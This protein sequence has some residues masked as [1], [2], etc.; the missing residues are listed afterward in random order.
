M[1][2]QATPNRTYLLASSLVELPSSFRVAETCELTR[3]DGPRAERAA[4]RAAAQRLERQGDVG[5]AASY[6]AEL[7]RMAVASRSDYSEAIEAAARSLELSFDN[8]LYSEYVSLLSLCGN[9]QSA[10]NVTSQKR[11][12]SNLDGQARRRLALFA[13]RAGD[14]VRAATELTD[15][16]RLEPEATDVLQ[17]LGTLSFSLPEQVSRERGILAFHEV[18]RRHRVKGAVLPSFEATLRAFELDPKNLFAAER[19]AKELESQGRRE[20]A[21]EV[22]RQSA[23]AAGDAMRHDV[24][25]TNALQVGDVIA[26]FAALLDGRADT[27]FEEQ[28]IVRGVEQLLSPRPGLSQGFDMVLSELGCADWLAVRLE[29]GPLLERWTDEASAQVVLARLE[30]GYFAHLDLAR[31]AYVR[32]I[33]V[34]PA[35]PEARARLTSFVGEDDSSDSLFQIGRA[36]CR[37]RVCQYV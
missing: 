9:W 29:L 20:A 7:F 12:V 37:E 34:Q 14:G 32:A 15:I 28:P 23:D 25:A 1:P 10:V 36:S 31:E 27:V 30:A 4:L 35:Q 21:D 17:A 33:T 11:P 13:F 5:D 18:A 22:W 26:A 3:Y 8:E 2:S 6:Y 24:R 19:L 16:A